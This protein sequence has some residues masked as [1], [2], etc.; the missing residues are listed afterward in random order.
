MQ[1]NTHGCDKCNDKNH[2][3][4]VLEQIGEREYRTYFDGKA[5]ETETHFK[6]KACSARWVNYIESG[7]GGYGNSWSP[8]PSHPAPQSVKH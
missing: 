3:G 1:S 6:C 5:R 2:R 8:G 4:E 7:L